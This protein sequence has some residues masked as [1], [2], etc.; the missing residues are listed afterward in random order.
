[1]HLV[2]E[3][4]VFWGD[5]WGFLK[6]GVKTYLVTPMSLLNSPVLFSV[7]TSTVYGLKYEHPSWISTMIASKGNYLSV[8][9]NI[10]L[11]EEGLRSEDPGHAGGETRGNSRVRDERRNRPAREHTPCSDE[12]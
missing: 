11:L 10:I 6:E 2:A 4:F 12:M 5:D 8:A 3:R 9:Q 7:F 1:M